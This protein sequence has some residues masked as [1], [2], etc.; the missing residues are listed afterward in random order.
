MDRE[1]AKKLA[2]S[3]FKVAHYG[4]ERELNASE[5]EKRIYEILI[6]KIPEDIREKCLFVR[7][8]DQYVTIKAGEA[9]DFFRFK[10]TP[11]VQW[12]MCPIAEAGQKKHRFDDRDDYEEMVHELDDL[13]EKSIEIYR[14]F[15]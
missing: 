5:N 15:N 12:I 7:V 14:R 10:F 11:R 3:L 2:S 13:I 8:S 6:K 4:E 9:W 1:E